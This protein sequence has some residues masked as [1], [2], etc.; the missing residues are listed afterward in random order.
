MPLGLELSCGPGAR[1]LL[2][3]RR[4]TAGHRQK[5]GASAR[6]F[7]RRSSATDLRQTPP[8]RGSCRRAPEGT[9]LP[10][11][12]S[13]GSGGGSQGRGLRSQPRPGPGMEMLFWAENTHHHTTTPPPR[14]PPVAPHPAWISIARPPPAPPTCGGRRSPFAPQTT[15]ARVPDPAPP[16]A[17]TSRTLLPRTAPRVGAL[18][19]ARG[20]GRGAGACALTDSRAR[21]VT[22][23]GDA[24]PLVPAPPPPHPRDTR[25][26]ALPRRARAP[27]PSHSAGSSHP[28]SRAG[29]GHARAPAPSHP[30]AAAR[31]YLCG[32]RQQQQREQQRQRQ[33]PPP[34]QPP[35]QPPAQ[36]RGGAAHVPDMPG[37]RRAGPGRA[38]LIAA[39]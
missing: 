33:P 19:R 13:A 3:R 32:G 15:L 35:E 30:R 5:L 20:A 39:P 27:A 37:P 24:H 9:I 26:P 2:Q 29:H 31:P 16:P 1:S 18:T 36:R 28:R 14:A 7:L 6:C 25:P 12:S 4:R 17:V 23:A 34:G 10:G 21:T 11:S 22:H 8:A 38:G